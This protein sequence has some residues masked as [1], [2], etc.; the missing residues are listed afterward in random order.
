MRSREAVAGQEKSFAEALARRGL[1][2]RTDLL[3]PLSNWLS[4]DFAHR[5]FD[6]LLRLRPAGQPAAVPAG[7]QGDGAVGCRARNLMA[8]RETTAFGDLGISPDTGD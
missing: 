1:G 2:V 5:R 6:A 7:K 8:G 4:P 3:K